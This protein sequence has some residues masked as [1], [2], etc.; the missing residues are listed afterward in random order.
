MYEAAARCEPPAP[1]KGAVK[2]TLGMNFSV[3]IYDLFA[4]AIPGTLYLALLVYVSDQ[5]S[6]V[7]A[8][9]LAAL[10]LP[11]L[12]VAG[13]V[14][15]YVLGHLTYPLGVVLDRVPRGRADAAMAAVRRSFIERVPDDRA[16]ALARADLFLIQ[17]A[18]EL[19]HPEAVAEVNRVRAVGLMV[20]NCA[21]AM[22]LAL[23]VAALM[24]FVGDNRAFAAT[25]A[26]LLAVLAFAGVRSGQKL[27]GWAAAK[28]LEVCYWMSETDL[29]L[30]A[31]PVVPASERQ[32]PHSTAEESP[33]VAER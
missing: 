6:W 23:P 9:D 29:P 27:R 22:L 12:I 3:G 26:F 24:T 11:I 32:P 13:T 18:A 15:S 2:R 20:R 14:L 25:T 7:A 30:P 16:K 31:T 1:T 4:Y 21:A 19:R 8:E 28:T 5:L 33:H 17:A 10:P